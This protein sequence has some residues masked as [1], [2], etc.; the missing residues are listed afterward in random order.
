MAESYGAKKCL[1][2]AQLFSDITT[3][4]FSELAEWR[5]GIA[6][7]TLRVAGQPYALGLSSC[8]RGLARLS[9]IDESARM[10]LAQRL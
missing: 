3:P 5:L 8:R 2:M 10:T 7:S 9:D 6:G 1:P 4:R